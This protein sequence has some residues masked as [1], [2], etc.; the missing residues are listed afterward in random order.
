MIEPKIESTPKTTEMSFPM[1]VIVS[2]VFILLSLWFSLLIIDTLTSEIYISLNRKEVGANI[3]QKITTHGK[4][5]YKYYIEYAFEFNDQSYSRKSLFQ[6]FNK[7]SKVSRIEYESYEI[8]NTV[9]VS[10]AGNNPNY[11]RLKDDVSIYNNFFFYIIG[12]ILFGAIGIN[13]TK[14][15]IQ[16]TMKTAATST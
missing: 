3:A 5:G 1:R 2:I 9:L 13:E 11:N 10:F 7:K 6:L 16:K 15:M 4:N 12:I 8:G 14:I